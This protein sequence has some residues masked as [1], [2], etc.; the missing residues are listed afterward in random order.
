VLVLRDGH[1]NHLSPRLFTRADWSF[2]IGSLFIVVA[3]PVSVFL[4]A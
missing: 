1:N 4:L 3:V 2:M